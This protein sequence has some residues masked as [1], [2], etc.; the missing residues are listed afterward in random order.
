ME[1]YLDKFQ[2]MDELK[3]FIEG[4]KGS[5]LDSEYELLLYV[6]GLLENQAISDEIILQGKPAK[7]DHYLVPMIV[8][9][10]QRGIITMASCSG[11][12]GEHQNSK[13][14][15]QTGYVALQFNNK[16]LDFLQQN[17]ID[18]LIEVK[19]STCYFV[20][21][22]SIYIP[23]EDDTILKE[24]WQLIWNTLRQWE[25]LFNQEK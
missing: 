10:N 23:S 2:S 19:E 1:N 12:Q 13:F 11:L 7:I 4:L 20:P 16:L 24:K 22:I 9:I 14:K 6:S 21:S 15:P 8:D 18:S 25:D 3:K 17:L 5:I